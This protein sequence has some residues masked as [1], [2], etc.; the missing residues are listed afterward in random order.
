MSSTNLTAGEASR[1]PLPPTTQLQGD[2]AARI[3]EDAP[4]VLLT[5]VT[6]FVATHCAVT[7]WLAGF[8]VRGT[9]RSEGSDKTRAVR[10]L[11][12]S[13]GVPAHGLELAECPDLTRSEGW[14][15]AAAGCDF[16]LHVASP[17]TTV[18]PKDEN[19]LIRPAID[20]TA[21]VLK[22]CLPL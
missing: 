14:A 19:E 12:D 6:G 1:E 3:A 9:T 20:G 21:N 7:L 16:C 11:A 13:I 15:E 22:V 8:R 18:I 10:A 2:S 17:Y 5:G 4:L